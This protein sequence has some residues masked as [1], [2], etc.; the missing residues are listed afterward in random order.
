MVNRPFNS[1]VKE[2]EIEYLLDLVEAQVQPLQVHEAF[3][4]TW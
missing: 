4:K 2:V 3:L 1:V